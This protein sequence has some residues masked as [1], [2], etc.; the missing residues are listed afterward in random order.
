MYYENTAT[1]FFNVNTYL[2]ISSL[3]FKDSSDYIGQIFLK[4]M[5]LLPS[6]LFVLGAGITSVLYYS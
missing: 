2:S 6:S 3:F 4:R 5:I 1:S